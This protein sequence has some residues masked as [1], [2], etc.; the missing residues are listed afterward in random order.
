MLTTLYYFAQVIL[1]SGIMMLYYWL[2]LRDKKFHQYNR[3]YLLFT[4]AIAWIV[5]L[6][7]IQW[8]PKPTANL[9]MY[10]LFYI[11]AENNSRIDSNLHR[12]WFQW[13]WQSMLTLGY[14]LI[15]LILLVILLVS[16]VR[17][18]R[19][20]KQH[21]INS[22]GDFFLIIT[23]VKGTPFSFFSYIFWN[24]QIDIQ[25]ESGKQIL[26]HEITHVQQKNSADK[27]FIQLVLIAGWFNPFFWLIKGEM[28]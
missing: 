27:L 2:V 9:P 28:S 15:S 24:E 12:N 5:P 23:N 25:S 11:V 13:N 16:V 10:E 21:P 8:E 20:L 7:K 3:F 1:C 14:V 4:A 6:I 18:Y 17:I 22:I 26:Q 19:I